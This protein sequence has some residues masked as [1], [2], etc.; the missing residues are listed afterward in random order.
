MSKIALPT[1]EGLQMVP[2]IQLSVAH[3][4]VITLFFSLKTIRRL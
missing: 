1:M 2:L 4:T 3:Q